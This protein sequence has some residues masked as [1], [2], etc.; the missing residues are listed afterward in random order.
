ML[1]RNKR[2]ING[3]IEMLSNM[4]GYSDYKMFC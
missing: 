4:N 3:L 2:K 1:F